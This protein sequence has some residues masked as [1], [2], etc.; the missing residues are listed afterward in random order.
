MKFVRIGRGGGGEKGDLFVEGVGCSSV[1][2]GGSFGWGA[3]AGAG[4]RGQKEVFFLLRGSVCHARSAGHTVSSRRT[5]IS[6]KSE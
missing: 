6:I 4:G 2:R 3:G 1:V 5:H